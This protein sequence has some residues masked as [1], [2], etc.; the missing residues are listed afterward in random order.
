MSFL[1]LTKGSPAPPA[2]TVKWS[3]GH[4]SLSQQVV[5][6]TDTRWVSRR[7]EIDLTLSNAN[8][9]GYMDIHYWNSIEDTT[10]GTYNW[11]NVDQARDYIQT[12]YPGKHYGVMIWGQAF[13]SVSSPATAP[14]CIPSYIYNTSSYGSS[15]T[16]GQFGF[17]TLDPDG[18][19][20]TAVSVAWWRP[21]VAARW[22][23]LFASLAAHQSA[24]QAGAGIA[25]YD[26][27][28][29]FY[30]VTGQE[31]SLALTSGSDFS[32]TGA[33]IQWQAT[34]AAIVGSF[35][36]TNVLTQNNWMGTGNTQS[37]VE[38]M[39]AVEAGNRLAMSTPDVFGASGAPGNL[40]WGQRGYLGL[41]G[42]PDQRPN[43]MPYFALV[44]GDGSNGNDYAYTVP[45]IGAAAQGTGTYGLN[46]KN[47]WWM[48]AIGGNGNW[49]TNVLPYINSNPILNTAYPANYP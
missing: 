3:P 26:A 27:D 11:S 10:A 48:I 45:D 9:L 20:T 12:N 13:G 39:V 46:A 25:N 38:A 43:A 24:G 21:S 32:P 36:K 29:Y 28:P 40:T 22:Q 47:I 1:I 8:V 19:H 33:I 2:H 31:S 23:A 37:Q 6:S 18:V 41:D 15:P 42:F 4:S 16:G 49:T 14:S 7:A 5:K 17:W 35:P 30:N 44:E 34:N